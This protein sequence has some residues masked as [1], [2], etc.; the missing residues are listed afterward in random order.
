M[1]QEKVRAEIEA[2]KELP[3][4]PKWAQVACAARSA[5]RV[6][7][8]LTWF[9]PDAPEDY[10]IAVDRAITLAERSAANAAAVADVIS[11]EDEAYQVARVV[12]SAAAEGNMS[13]GA[14]A[15]VAA[16]AGNAARATTCG[17]TDVAACSAITRAAEA[18]AAKGADD[19]DAVRFAIYDDFELL[20]V[21]AEREKWT[22]E[23]PVPPEF[24]GA[25]WPNGAPNGWPEK[26]AGETEENGPAL[27]R[28]EFS[29]PSGL[30]RE[31]ADALIGELIER[32]NALHHAHGGSGLRIVDGNVYEP[33]PSLV[34]VGEGGG[35]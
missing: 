10:V 9:W 18:A 15:D 8:L 27:L 5:R 12:A 23:T 22:D 33:Q 32:A 2:F 13:K 19:D 24:F 25:L 16:A 21:A 28:I 1:G 26:P 34:P 6:Q 4:L 30:D 29:I 7:P 31:R 17:A 11:A 14:A 35:F 20:N 3:A